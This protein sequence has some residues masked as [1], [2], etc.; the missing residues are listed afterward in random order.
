MHLA[1]DQLCCFIIHV[2]NP[3]YPREARLAH[4]EGVVKLNLVIADDGSIA[5]LQAVSCDPVLL[6]STMDAV[7]Q[8]RFA[9]GGWAVGGPREIEVPLSFTF[10]IEDPAKPAYLHLSNGE[11][12]RA[13]DVRELTDRIEYTTDHRAHHIS[14]D[15]V[16]GINGC[17]RA[18]VITKPKAKEDDCVPSGGPSF[19]IR[20]IPLLPAVKTSDAVRPA[21]ECLVYPPNFRDESETPVAMFGY[22]RSGGR[23]HVRSETGIPAPHEWPAGTNDRG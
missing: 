2:V 19:L 6:K 17:A 12:I 15:S 21:L 5:D 16:T 13:D 3:M 23:I 14:P 22:A 7:R 18:S 10:K 1:Q 4:T 20:A 11:V 8:W 9:I